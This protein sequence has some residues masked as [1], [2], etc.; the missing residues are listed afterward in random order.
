MRTAKPAAAIARIAPAAIAPTSPGLGDQ[1]GSFADTGVAV[2]RWV[3]PVVTSAGA[4][5]GSC[6]MPVEIS[7]GAAGASPVTPVLISEGLA[8]G[9]A[10]GVCTPRP[11]LT[12]DAVATAAGVAAEVPPSPAT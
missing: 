12:S 8:A 6:T 7:A 11:V 4:A 2:G 9:V 3:I 5:S 1:E 10:A